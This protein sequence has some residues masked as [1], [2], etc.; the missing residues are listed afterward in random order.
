MGKKSKNFLTLL[1][2][3]VLTVI[4]AFYFEE[5]YRSFVRYFFKYFSDNN[6]QFV[7]KNFHLFA[8]NYFVLSFGVFC[9][10]FITL[11]KEKTVK[12]IFKNIFFVIILFVTTT[13][14]LSYIYSV[15][16]IAE[17]TA[18]DDGI[19]KLQYNEINYDSIFVTSLL[20]SLVPL[21][22]LKIKKNL[23]ISG[24]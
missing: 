3:F 21:I 15:I 8:S 16:K 14:I 11:I 7:G 18:C 10:I 17:C 24:K 20:V 1:L 19:R 9:V 6:I 4:S 2:A 5:Y 12:S 22:L 13:I 23:R